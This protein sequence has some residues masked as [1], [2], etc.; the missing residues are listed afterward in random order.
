MLSYAV[1]HKNKFPLR[2]H[3]KRTAVLCMEGSDNKDD[4]GSNEI[5]LTVSNKDY[6]FYFTKVQGSLANDILEFYVSQSGSANFNDIPSGHVA[7]K[8]GK[9]KGTLRIDRIYWL[10]TDK[11][12]I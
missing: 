7:I 3:F 2:E 8:V 10:I 6:R 11:L 4:S 5:I 12:D 9:S 1:K